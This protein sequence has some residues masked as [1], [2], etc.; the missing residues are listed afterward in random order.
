MRLVVYFADQT[1]KAWIWLV[2]CFIDKCKKRKWWCFNFYKHIHRFNRIHIYKCYFPKYIDPT[3]S[4]I[5]RSNS[6]KKHQE[7][8]ILNFYIKQ[9]IHETIC[10]CKKIL[11]YIIYIIFYG[12][13]HMII[14]F[15]PAFPNAS[16]LKWASLYVEIEIKCYKYIIYL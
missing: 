14:N 3:I 2:V 13:Y 4:K 8:F 11:N 9:E 16:N 1:Y 5:H 7:F 6:N 15:L 10:Q 12:K